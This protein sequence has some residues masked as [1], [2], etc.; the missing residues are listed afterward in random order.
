MT[1]VIESLQY[2]FVLHW[3]NW[4]LD[5]Y[6]HL[7]AVT[8]NWRPASSPF[9]RYVN[10]YFYTEWYLVIMWISAHGSYMIIMTMNIMHVCMYICTYV[11]SVC[12]PRGSWGPPSPRRHDDRQ[13]CHTVS[14]L[15]KLE[16]VCFQRQPLYLLKFN[17]AV[18]RG[19][20]GVWSIA[21]VDYMQTWYAI[22]DRS[23]RFPRRPTFLYCR[24]PG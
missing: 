24:L 13:I 23:N 12:G 15:N 14:N 11:R 20:I 18:Y 5:K 2:V 16:L 22:V 9:P 7:Y 17:N 21:E 10:S 1:M 19:S 3:W 8:I 6:L 4:F